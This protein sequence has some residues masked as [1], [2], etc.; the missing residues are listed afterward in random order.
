MRGKPLKLDGAWVCVSCHADLGQPVS[1]DR[2]V[3]PPVRCDDCRPVHKLWTHWLSG[4][5]TAASKVARAIK[6]G[7]LQRPA[8]FACVDCGNPA[9]CYDH[10]DYSRPLDVVP[11]CLS[12]NVRR[13]SAKPLNP[14]LVSALLLA[15]ID[16][17]FH[18]QG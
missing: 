8:L 9:K 12:C 7:Q 11:V 3:R 15:R 6:G 5:Q 16:E 13:S 14:F 4:R 1:G 10:R 17:I 18:P 2:R